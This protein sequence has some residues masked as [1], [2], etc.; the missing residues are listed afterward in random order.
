MNPGL[1]LLLRRSAWGKARYVLRRMSTARGAASYGLTALFLGAIVAFQLWA[2]LRDASMA[3]APERLRATV[4]PLVMAGVVVTCLSSRR[5]YFT[6]AEVDFL[7]PA[8]VGRREL[9]LFNLLSRLGV[10]LLSGAWMALFVSRFAPSA[11]NGAAAVVLAFAFGFVT[12]QAVGLALSALEAAVPP[13]GR[14][15]GGVALLAGLGLAIWRLAA[16]AAARAGWPPRPEAIVES[17]L[18]RALSLPARPFG[19]LYAAEGLAAGALWAAVCAGMIVLEVGAMVALDVAYT[20]RSLA[21]SRRVHERLRRLSTGAAVVADAPRRFRV[22]VPP[23]RFL[24]AAAPLARRQLVEL[25][26]NPRALI[27]PGVVMGIWIALM[28]AMSRAPGGDGRELVPYLTLLGVGVYFPVLLGTQVPFDFRRDL[29]RMALLRSLPLAPSA[30]AVGQV[31]PSVVAAVGVQLATVGVVAALTGTLE[32]GW[33]LAFAV[34]VGPFTWAV[35]ATENALFLLMPYRVSSR[36]ESNMGFVGKAML[37][38][39]LKAVI[40]G[41]LGGV[42][43]LAAWGAQA[44]TGSAAVAVGAGVVVLGVGCIPLTWILGQVFVAFDISRDLPG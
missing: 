32:P 36:G 28:V 3:V 25:G 6:P 19:E 35:V 11:A 39:V 37:A 9:L 8:P 40:L 41:A 1:V 42:A 20:E 26:R 7:F 44:L 33:L 38:M 14:R 17:P 43:V 34:C 12:A 23:L 30:V 13:R 10:Q 2:L 29:D 15:L 31:F 18:V 27:V 24:G 4:P 5:L 16:D 22:P 21:A